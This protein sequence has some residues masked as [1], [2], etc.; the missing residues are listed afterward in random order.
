MVEVF[1]G[2]GGRAQGARRVRG[3][4]CFEVV[5]G[6]DEYFVVGDNRA[7]SID[8]RHWGPVGEQAIHGRVIFRY[9]PLRQIGSP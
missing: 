9:W 7:L 3:M 2:A 8:S 1:D 6:P 4:N 5:L